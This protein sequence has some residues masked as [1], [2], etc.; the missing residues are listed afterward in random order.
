[1]DDS[2]A[3]SKAMANGTATAAGTARARKRSAMD[4]T[5][6]WPS[7]KIWSGVGVGLVALHEPAEAALRPR[8]PWRRSARNAGND[9]PR[10][11]C[12][13]ADKG[14]EKGVSVASMVIDKSAVRSP[15]PPSHEGVK[16]TP[17]AWLSPGGI[18]TSARVPP[19]RLNSSSESFGSIPTSLKLQ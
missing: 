15:V 7:L 19:W 8:D 6:A 13:V 5:G 14:M 10:P 12:T 1:M 17:S 11:Y 16:F 3:P 9:E 2:T 4:V 18:L